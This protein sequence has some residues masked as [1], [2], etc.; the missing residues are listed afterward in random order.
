MRTIREH[1]L[2]HVELRIYELPAVLGDCFGQ[3][4]ELHRKSPVPE[5][6]AITA[7]RASHSSVTGPPSVRFALAALLAVARSRSCARRFGP[8][9]YAIG[10]SADKGNRQ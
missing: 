9:P 7:L 8:M 6:S 5:V 4:F 3:R 2:R 10:Q 1:R